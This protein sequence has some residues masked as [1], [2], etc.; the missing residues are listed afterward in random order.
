MEQYIGVDLHKAFFQVTAMDQ[1]GGRLW[2]DRFPHSAEGIAAFVARCSGPSRIAVEA[3]G[4]TWCFTDA[5][6][7]T[8]RAVV[9]VDPRKTRL[10]AGHAAKTDRLDARR[11]ADALRRDSVVAVYYPPRP[12]RQLRELCRYRAS[13]VRMRVGVK[14]RI[15]ALLLRQAIHPPNCSD[16]FGV[17]GQRWL[18]TVQLPGFAAASLAGYRQLFGWVTE[19]LTTA[20]AA[21]QREAAQDPIAQALDQLVGIGPILGLFLRA[22]IGDITRF[23]DGPHLASYAGLVP[24]VAQSGGHCYYG[25]ITREGSPWLRWALVEAATHRTRGRDAL[26]RWAM[27]LALRKGA[28]KAR[29][30]VARRLCDDV[31]AAW[32]RE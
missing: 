6:V 5:A 9:I 16:L 4:P 24:S 17:R 28:L 23:A 32:P 27:Q 15:H 25:A 3:S 7:S 10:K 22:E 18:G 13:V 2:E 30:A 1:A 21:V 20:T 26:G 12:V 19:Q 29:V 8:E 11:L 31:W 14:Q